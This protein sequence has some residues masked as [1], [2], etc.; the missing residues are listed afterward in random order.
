MGLNVNIVA[1]NHFVN[2]ML[3]NLIKNLFVPFGISFDPKR[4]YKDGDCARMLRRP[5]AIRHMALPPR[6]Q[7]HQY[8]RYEGL[9]YTDTDIADFETRLARI[10]RREVHRV[11]K[12]AY[13]KFN[14]I[15]H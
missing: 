8:L 2:G 3:F 12:Q 11:Q 13:S 1:W 5:R 9:Q 10:Y 7:R 4:Y 14:T 6:D 15:A